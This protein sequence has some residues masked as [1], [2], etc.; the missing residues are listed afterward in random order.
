MTLAAAIDTT[1]IH[2]VA[3]RTSGRTALIT[4]RPFHSGLCDPIAMSTG[5]SSDGYALQGD[6]TTKQ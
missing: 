5:N 2:S 1:R 6:I 4:T 3:G